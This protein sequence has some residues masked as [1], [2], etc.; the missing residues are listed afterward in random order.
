MKITK[1]VGV[2]P[3]GYAD[4]ARMANEGAEITITVREPDI[5]YTMSQPTEQ[6]H[7]IRLKSGAEIYTR[8]SEAIE[9]I[10][11]YLDNPLY[12]VAYNPPGSTLVIDKRPKGCKCTGTMKCDICHPLEFPFDTTTKGKGTE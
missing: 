2:F 3:L 4:I 7:G 8:D 11:K 5:D 1:I 12:R 10:N 6:T 9:R